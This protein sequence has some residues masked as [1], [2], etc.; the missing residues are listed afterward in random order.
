VEPDSTS[1]TPQTS[2]IGW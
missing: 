2:N 1:Y